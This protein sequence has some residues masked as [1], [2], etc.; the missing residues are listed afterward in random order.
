MS[1]SYQPQPDSLAHKVCE[2]FRRHQSEELTVSDVAHKFPPVQSRAV[3]ACLTTPT[4]HG[5]LKR[6]R[7][8]RGEIVYRA[9]PKL[10]GLDMD[11]VHSARP[12]A[13]PVPTP[14]PAPAPTPVAQAAPRPPAAAPAPAPAATPVQPLTNRP[15]CRGRHVRLPELD[16]SQL[17]VR[18][19]LPIP[20]GQQS[21]KGVTRYDD[22]FA[23]L[24]EPGDSRHPIDI[25]YYA[26]LGKAAK[27]YGQANGVTLLVRRIDSKTCGVWRK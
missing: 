25:A 3:T 1:P 21:A 14:A 4:E 24:R 12:A 18:R 20:M 27:R 11:K 22:L 7:N 13:A 9:G 23:G 17:P 6:V 5:L 15:S 16:L 8:E 2:F 10:M 19:D 26:T